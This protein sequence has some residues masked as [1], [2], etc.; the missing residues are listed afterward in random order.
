MSKPGIVVVDDEV[1]I[2]ETVRL[3]LEHAGFAVSVVEDPARA[4][5]AV[6]A[7]KPALVLMDLYMPGLDGRD[8]CR[9]L[10]ADADTKAIPVV[11]FTGSNEPVDVVTGLDSGAVEYLAKPIDGEVLVRKIRD[12]LKQKA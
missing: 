6:K 5:D 2:R 7:A 10:K 3:S 11:L 8:L 4:F 1:L 9:R 12:I